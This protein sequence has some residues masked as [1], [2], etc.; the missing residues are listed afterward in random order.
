MVVSSNLE[1]IQSWSQGI[2]WGLKYSVAFLLPI[3][4][5]GF[6]EKVA[7]CGLQWF[8]EIVNNKE[9]YNNL[10]IEIYLSAL[11]HLQWNSIGRYSCPSLSVPYL[12][13]FHTQTRRELHMRPSSCQRVADCLLALPLGRGEKCARRGRLEMISFWL[14][15]WKLLV[16]RHRTQRNQWNTSRWWGQNVEMAIEPP[17]CSATLCG[18]L[19]MIREAVI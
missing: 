2:Q 8:C 3:W 10:S 1:H 11:I 17:L 5:K 18:I 14:L 15:C 4:W 19:R 6:I 9:R 16:G 7:K 13:L 12:S